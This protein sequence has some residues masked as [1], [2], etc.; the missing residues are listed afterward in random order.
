MII[1]FV[2]KTSHDWQL[3]NDNYKV[4]LTHEVIMI[5]HFDETKIIM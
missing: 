5:Y 2:S 4:L 1:Q 3:T